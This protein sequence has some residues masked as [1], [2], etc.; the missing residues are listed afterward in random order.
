MF[1]DSPENKGDNS[2]NNNRE[3]T[4][5]QTPDRQPPSIL[6]NCRKG[7]SVSF[8]GTQSNKNQSTPQEPISKSLFSAAMQKKITKSPLK[9][10][11]KKFGR[12]EANKENSVNETFEQEQSSSTLDDIYTPHEA[13]Q[14]RGID[15]TSMEDLFVEMSFFARLGFLQP[16]SC[17]KCAYHQTVGQKQQGNTTGTGISKPCNRL[18]AWRKDAN[19]LLHPDKLEGNLLVVSCASATK[20]HKGET[21]SNYVWDRKQ[22]LFTGP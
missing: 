22:R 2:S 11:S 19:V 16:P 14:I 18:V 13:T 6:G 9:F 1:E 10:D 3:S 8:D 4:D 5:E 21:V 20:L 17:L 12:D 7:L 15:Q